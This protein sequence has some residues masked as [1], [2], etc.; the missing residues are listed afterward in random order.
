MSYYVESGWD[1]LNDSS[2]SS[3]GSSSPPSG[4]NGGGP[5]PS[6]D[7]G[8]DDSGG[9]I[10]EGW[11][12][13][14]PPEPAPAQITVDTSGTGGGIIDVAAEQDAIDDALAIAQANQNPPAPSGPYVPDWGENMVNVS[15]VGGGPNSPGSLLYGINLEDY[16]G[17]GANKLEYLPQEFLQM[18]G[19]GVVV[20]GSDAVA[21][22]ALGPGFS[23]DPQNPQEEQA[24]NE[25]VASGWDPNLGTWGQVE[26]QWNFGDP[27][28]L[29]EG[30]MTPENYEAYLWNFNPD[31]PNQILPH[32]SLSHPFFTGGQE[33]FYDMMDENWG[34]E[35]RF[36]DWWYDDPGTPWGQEWY[37]YPTDETQTAKLPHW[38]S[39]AL[40]TGS[41]S[42][43][44]MQPIYG[45]EFGS[46]LMAS[47]LHVAGLESTTGI[48]YQG[49]PEFGTIEMPI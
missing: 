23:G 13:N 26:G 5:A 8:F 33:S 7:Y 10:G 41:V 6:I 21:N 30:S 44:E 42:M 18:L 1:F 46:E 48:P 36:D 45:A 32:E 3:S 9:F 49:R 39:E 37:D 20:G 4:G 25:A 2:G 29:L 27:Y 40:P 15:H 16:F 24:W 47:P 35:N 43:G 19:Q 17:E 14:P 12:G 22:D 28:G 34:L 31:N 11:G 38:R